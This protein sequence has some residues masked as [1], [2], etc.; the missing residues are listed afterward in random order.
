MAMAMVARAILM[1]LALLMLGLMVMALTM[2]IALL[3]LGLMAALMVPVPV[4][5][6]LV[7]VCWRGRGASLAS[8]VATLRWACGA[9]CR[10]KRCR[11]LCCPPPQGLLSRRLDSYRRLSC[12]PVSPQMNS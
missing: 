9:Q 5:M 10:A 7:P 4:L 8:R 11:L 3:A 1:V 12:H 2:A 6:V